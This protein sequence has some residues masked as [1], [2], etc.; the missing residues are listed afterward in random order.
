MMLGK[1]HAQMTFSKVT[2]KYLESPGITEMWAESNVLGE[3]IATNILK[4]KLWNWSYVHTSSVT[5][6]CR[7]Y[8]GPC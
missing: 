6:H 8:C 7:R 4:G 1:F 3:S 5:K 2:G